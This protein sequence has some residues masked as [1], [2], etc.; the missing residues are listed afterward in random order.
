MN[1]GI[2]GVGGI[3]GYFGGKLTKLLKNDGQEKDLNIYFVARNKHLEEI[4]KNGLIL[5]NQEEGEFVCKPTL[6]TDNFEDL[7]QLDLCFLC[8]K[9][10][11]LNNSLNLLRNK[12]K[13]DTK[14]IP[15]LNGIDIYDRVRAV[16]PNGVIYP[17]CAYVGTHIERYGK[18]SQVGG[19][20]TILFGS[21]PANPD[22]YPQ[23]ILDLFDASNI[24]YKWC[25]Q[26]NVEIWSKYIFIAAYGMVTAS[27]NKTMGQVL[28]SPYLSDKVMEIMREIEKIARKL[29]IDLSDN[30]VEESFNKGRGFTYETKT[31][32][33]RDFE[34]KNKQNEAELF[35]DSIIRIGSQLEVEIPVSIIVNQKLKITM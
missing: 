2:I 3:G 14:I 16:I 11:D 9:S 6:A 30:I 29:G 24:K 19:S 5:S 22:V 18:V 26:P 20:C 10:Y 27:E 12:I 7:P 15:L 1:I 17:A 32:F 31:S 23:D 25:K 4:K 13:D 34:Q 35:G 21:D 28:E 8:V 33:H